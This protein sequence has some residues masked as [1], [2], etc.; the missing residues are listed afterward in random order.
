[1]ASRTAR[2]QNDNPF[3]NTDVMNK[4]ESLTSLGLKN[5][6][7]SSCAQPREMAA[8]FE[9]NFRENA[10]EAPAEARVAGPKTE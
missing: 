6:G 9:K 7:R 2:G 4:D 8:M 1:M 5:L 3:T 10:P